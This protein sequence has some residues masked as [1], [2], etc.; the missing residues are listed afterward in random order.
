MPQLGGGM[1]TGRLE[2][3]KSLWI[4]EIQPDWNEE[5]VRTNASRAASDERTSRAGLFSLF[6]KSAGKAFSRSDKATTR[7]ATV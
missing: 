7:K 3:V 4:G 6:S 2:D 1:N 5:Y